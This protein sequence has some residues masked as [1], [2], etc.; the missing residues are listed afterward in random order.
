MQR[1]GAPTLVLAGLQDNATEQC[2]DHL[3]GK[4]GLFQL[5]AFRN[6]GTAIEI[7]GERNDWKEQADYTHQRE[8]DQTAIA[9]TFQA[10]IPAARKQQNGGKSQPR[11]IESKFQ[12]P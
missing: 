3:D 5:A 1:L 7:V 2:H 10:S 6:S 12:A 9:I 8:H 11:E 4:D